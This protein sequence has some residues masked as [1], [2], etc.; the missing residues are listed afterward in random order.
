MQNRSFY[1]A[2]SISPEVITDGYTCS[3][4]VLMNTGGPFRILMKMGM[5]L[6]KKAGYAAPEM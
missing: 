1:N 3:R 5:S 6:P 4:D 2:V